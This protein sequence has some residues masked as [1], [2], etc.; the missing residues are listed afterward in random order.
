MD[1]NEAPHD[2]DRDP[3]RDPLNELIALASQAEDAIRQVARLTLHAPP[4]APADLDRI[5]GHLAETVAALPQVSTQL[6][7]ILGGSRDSYE[8]AMDGM[9][10]TTDPALAV[11]AARFHLD[12]ARDPALATYRRLNAAR[13][14]VAHIRATPAT[15]GEVTQSGRALRRP[16]DRQPRTQPPRLGPAR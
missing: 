11:D 10:T 7:Q 8:L 5:L 13:T 1:L 14:E 3:D 2:R 6:G 12:E 4:L 16:E 15:G 9:T